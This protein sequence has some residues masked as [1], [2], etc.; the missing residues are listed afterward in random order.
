MLTS[1]EGLVSNLTLEITAILEGGYVTN[2]ILNK[3][4][5]QNFVFVG[6][7][8][9]GGQ[10]AG[11][12]II[13]SKVVNVICDVT[14]ASGTVIQ[15]KIGEGYAPAKLACKIKGNAKDPALLENVTIED[16]TELENVI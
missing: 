11:K 8:I 13:A 6:Q 2:V 9:K 3:G 5:M 12:I 16:N 10:L 1:D 7:Q 4:L 14:L 15:G